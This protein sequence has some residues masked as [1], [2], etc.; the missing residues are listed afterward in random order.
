MR[1][2]SRIGNRNSTT[3]KSISEVQTFAELIKNQFENDA[4]KCI[5]DIL[6]LEN[7]AKKSDSMRNSQTKE[8]LQEMFQVHSL[9][10]SY[11]SL[12][13]DARTSEIVKFSKT[14][15]I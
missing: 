11:S 9:S 14:L 8:A 12:L 3:N 5:N 1:I 10:S 2:E 13:Q 6:K 15:W 4:P 7:S